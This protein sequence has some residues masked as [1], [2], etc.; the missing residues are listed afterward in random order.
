LTGI[1]EDWFLVGI[2]VTI[3][4]KIIDYLSRH[5]EGVDDDELAKALNLKYRQQA[6]SRCRQLQSE[7]LVV[8]RVVQ[9]KIHNYWVGGDQSIPQQEIKKSKMSSTSSGK[10]EDN[11]FWEGNVQSV[12]VQYLATQGYKIRSVADT[13]RRQPGKDIIAEKDG[14]PLW[15]SVKGYPKG[16]DRTR[17]STQAGHWFKD[18]IFDVIEYRGESDEAELAVALPD[19]PRYRSF[20]EK[21]SWFQSAAKF[22]YFWVQESGDITVSGTDFNQ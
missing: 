11:W 14:K 16:T 12:V 7:G 1:E 3:R 2:A 20:A 22:V 18:V 15:V 10:D 5:P 19:Y 13:A 4:E 21:I 8:R 17:P 9:G 6:N